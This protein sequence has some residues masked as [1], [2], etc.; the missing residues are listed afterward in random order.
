[1][2][3]IVDEG[4]DFALAPVSF[5]TWPSRNAM[6]RMRTVYE[7]T[8][9]QLLADVASLPEVNFTFKRISVQ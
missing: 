4:R 8:D 2:P 5:L 1:M 7:R 6:Q 9:G 3:V